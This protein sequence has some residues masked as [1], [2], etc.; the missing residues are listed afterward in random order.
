M[1]TQSA[2]SEHLDDQLW[3]LFVDAKSS[4]AFLT[5]WLALQCRMV[6]EARSA[7]LLLEESQGTFVPAAVWPRP[8]YDVTHLAEASQQCLVKREGL[9]Y[10]KDSLAGFV[11]VAYPIEV[12]RQLFGA[13]VLEV[14]ET[15]SRELQHGLRS[16][17]W[18]AGWLEALFLRR[19]ME[20]SSQ[21]IEQ[22][23]I[24]V[25][26]AALTGEKISLQES[27]LALANELATRFACKR[28]SIGLERKNSV[29][30]VSI[31]HNAWFDRKSQLVASI[32]NAMEEALDQR[33][34][35]CY[36]AVSETTHI[37]SVAHRDLA[38]NGSVCSVV[39]RAGGRGIGVITFERPETGA[40][41]FAD[42]Q[43]LQA[44]ASLVG[45][46]LE[47]KELSSR[48]IAGKPAQKLHALKLAFV[49]PRRPSFRFVLSVGVIAL[50]GITFG[51]SEFRVSAKAVIEGEQQR[52][53]AAPFDGFVVS[54][55][56]R[57]GQTVHKDD[58]LA[59]LDDRD[60]RVEQQKWFSEREQGEGKYRD[61]MVKHDRT[62]AGTAAAEVAEAKAQLA[63]VEEKL[64]RTQIKAPFDG[65]LVTGDLSQ[66][67][68]SPVQLGDQLF[69]IAPLNA[70]RVIL[71]VDERDIRYVS[72]RQ[73]GSVM[74]TGI[75]GEAIP[76]EVKNIAVPTAEDGQNLFRVEA[77]LTQSVLPLRP[78]MEG[79]GKIA[80]GER[81][82]AWIWTHRLLDWLRLQVWN[83]LP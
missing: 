33:K 30:L 22:S 50:L 72:P 13:V 9:I 31:S 1:N 19:K 68:G 56:F 2:R 40:F 77:Q 80:V 47:M 37:I 63:L 27:A 79:V 46:T 16:L 32:E 10:R 38:E 52:V 11:H 49:D 15:S 51:Q 60:L 78:G 81:R 67:L 69:E 73:Q 70:Y 48:W 71:K 59:Q 82:I 54:A 55:H 23:R 3:G 7:L 74:L 4:Q 75:T 12:D 76:L 43:L 17:H 45:P 44:A 53:V 58:V 65:V 5:A 34:T 41:S 18:G 35:I 21:F 25:D 26:L 29:R 83:W 28:V 24:A 8:D 66:S 20:Q 6:S 14:A 57:A 62:A 42:V 36:P 39:L 64:S 61:A